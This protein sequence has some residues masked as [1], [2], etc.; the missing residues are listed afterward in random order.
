MTE[1]V[2]LLVNN[3]ISYDLMVVPRK[4]KLTDSLINEL[5][6]ILSNTKDEF[7]QRFNKAKA[8]SP[9]CSIIFESQITD[10]TH[11]YIEEN[12]TAYKDF[13]FN[14][15]L[16]VKFNTSRCSFFGYYR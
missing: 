3:T 5:C 4:V 11:S 2:N 14:P 12:F 8:Y 1:T 6:I 13:M 16:Y 7:M 10:K 15:E 9:L